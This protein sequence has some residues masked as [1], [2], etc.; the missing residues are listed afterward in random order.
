MAPKYP[1][2]AMFPGAHVALKQGP[3]V[4]ASPPNLANQNPGSSDTTGK[5][6]RIARLPGACCRIDT[7]IVLKKAP[8]SKESGGTDVQSPKVRLL[9]Q[10]L[11][12]P[13]TSGSSVR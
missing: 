13:V 5:S 7:E 12:G 10:G 2:S 6:R 9:A 4:P 3:E 1:V 8:E 11:P